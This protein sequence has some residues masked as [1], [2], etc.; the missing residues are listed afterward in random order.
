[1]NP[2]STSKKEKTEF[3]IHIPRIL[4]NSIIKQL[5]LSNNP[6]DL[7]TVETITL[8]SLAGALAGTMFNDTLTEQG[9][10]KKTLKKLRSEMREY[11]KDLRK[12]E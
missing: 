11:F 2:L 5:K 1:M 10:P 3:F 7:K 12:L 8:W 9:T 6:P 4:V